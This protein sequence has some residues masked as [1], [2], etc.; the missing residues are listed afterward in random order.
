MHCMNLQ[1]KGWEYTSS[2]A[3]IASSFFAFYV[4]N[5]VCTSEN[6]SRSTGKEAKTVPVLCKACVPA[7][8]A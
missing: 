8:L 7:E 4:F 2:I 6:V 3:S 5:S 1:G